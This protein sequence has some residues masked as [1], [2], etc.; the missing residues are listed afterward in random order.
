MYANRASLIN[1]SFSLFELKVNRKRGHGGLRDIQSLSLIFRH[2]S[3]EVA[4]KLRETGDQV[5]AGK[6]FCVNCLPEII[7]HWPDG[8][9]CLSHPL[10]GVDIFPEVLSDLVNCL[11]RRV[12]RY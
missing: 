11:S 1:G 3:N 7:E 5:S 8:R 2:S 9:T 6:I 4:S 10:P 12:G